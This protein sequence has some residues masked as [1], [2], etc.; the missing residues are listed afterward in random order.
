MPFISS[1]KIVKVVAPEPC[2]FFW[3][4]ESIAVIPNGAKIY[5]AK[6]IATFVNGPVNLLNNNPKNPPG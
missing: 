4:P 3:M 2:F 5:F 6:G 1:S